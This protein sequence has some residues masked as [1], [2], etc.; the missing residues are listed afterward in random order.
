MICYLKKNGKHLQ[1][2][3]VNPDCLEIET[4]C[5]DSWKIVPAALNLVL[6]LFFSITPVNLILFGKKS[7]YKDRRSPAC[8][9]QPSNFLYFEEKRKKKNLKLKTSTP[10]GFRQKYTKITLNSI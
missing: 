1:C 8:N 5:F 10:V 7:V 9:T 6:P 4:L 2:P 3:K